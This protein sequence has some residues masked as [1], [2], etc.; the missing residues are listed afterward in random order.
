MNSI[1]IIGLTGLFCSGKSTLEKILEKEFG[2][3]IIDLDK[4][5]HIALQEK[6]EAIIKIF[7]SNILT[8]EK[9]DRKKLGNIVFKNKK[10]L[11]KLNS[12]VWPF[13]RN[14]VEEKIK[15]LKDKKIC[16][17]GAVLF[18][19]GLDILCN[20]IFIVKANIFNILKRARKRN[21]YSICKTLS[22]LSKQKVLKLAKKR[23]KNTEILY[24]NNNSTIEE[25]KRI[26]KIKL[27]G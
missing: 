18:E 1:N 4:I 14:Y 15:E 21:N 25:L 24:V 26:I 27:E 20:K 17:N 2:Y 16:I 10:E 19:I 12:I 23:E 3:F 7:G 5:G 11:V 6:K 22:I 8:D 9:I 13:I